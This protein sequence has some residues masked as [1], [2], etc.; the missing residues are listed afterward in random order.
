VALLS[1]TDTAGSEVAATYGF[2]SPS[3]FA[4]HFDW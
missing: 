2:E 3:A 4:K 1:D